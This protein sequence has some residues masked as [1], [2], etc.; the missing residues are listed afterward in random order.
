VFLEDSD[1]FLMLSKNQ[2]KDGMDEHISNTLTMLR[3]EY[4]KLPTFHSRVLKKV[5]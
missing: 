2:Y 4:K 5:A 3:E 1:V